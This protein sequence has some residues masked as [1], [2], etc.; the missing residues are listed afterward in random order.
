MAERLPRLLPADLDEA[1][2]HLYDLLVSGPRQGGPVP[3]TGADGQLEGP[4][5]AMLFA[6]GTGAPLLGLGTAVRF[7][8]SLAPRV[9]EIAT[10]AIAAHSGSEYELY[11]HERLGRQAGLTAAECAA[12]RGQQ[13]P[14][15]ADP[16]EQAVLRV[17]R[18]LLDG[19]DIPDDLYR[20]A[21]RALGPAGLVELVTLAGYYLTLA[22]LM[23]TFR[24]GA[25]EPGQAAPPS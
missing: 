6:P 9:R 5:N 12:L 10:L 16:G 14:G 1:Q 15:L 19:G 7:G 4:F 8:S 13:D 24:V 20:A 25:P 17:T 18:R 21:E 3:L 11:A 23:R 2:R 22:M